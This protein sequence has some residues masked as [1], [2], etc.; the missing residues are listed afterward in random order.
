MRVASSSSSD[1][2]EVEALHA[3]IVKSMR[4]TQKSHHDTDLLK[5]VEVLAPMAMVITDSH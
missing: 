5:K 1:D 4:Y 3:I 2:N